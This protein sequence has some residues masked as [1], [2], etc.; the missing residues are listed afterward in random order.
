MRKGLGCMHSNLS[1]IAIVSETPLTVQLN[2]Q[3][4]GCSLKGCLVGQKPV[5]V[6]STDNMC[7]VCGKRTD[8][9]S[10]SIL[11]H[12]YK[13]YLPEQWKSHNNHDNVVLCV[14]L[15]GEV[16]CRFPARSAATS[17]TTFT[18]GNSLKSGGFIADPSPWCI[19]EKL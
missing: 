14:E 17:M 4:K 19:T 18:A 3:P 10:H 11:P 12:K 16:D 2:F 6:T 7:V 5:N 15:G 1:S 13:R 9:I 8:Y